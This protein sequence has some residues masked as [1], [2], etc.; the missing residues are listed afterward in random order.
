MHSDSWLLLISARISHDSIRLH[1]GH[2]QSPMGTSLCPYLA[3]HSRKYTIILV[4]GHRYMN[5]LCR[6]TKSIISFFN[7]LF[8]ILHQ[9]EFVF[10]T[11][12]NMQC[13]SLSHTYMSTYFGHI[14]VKYEYLTWIIQAD[15]FR[16]VRFEWH[17]HI[18]RRVVLW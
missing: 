18:Y 9:R 8:A 11:W 16:V 14:K 12:N 10:T 2:I 6:W 13:C 1:Y 7:T 5:K 17:F 4:R 15:V 3:Y